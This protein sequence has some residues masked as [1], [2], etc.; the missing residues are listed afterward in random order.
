MIANWKDPIT[1][2]FWILGGTF[3]LF[4]LVGFIIFYVSKNVQRMESEVKLQHT[5]ELKHQREL[6]E[7]SVRIQE[8]ERARIAS[9]IHDDLI[10]QLHR[11][12]LGNEDDK[13][14][15]LLN[16]SIKTARII[17]HDLIPPMLKELPFKTLIYDFL[18]PYLK[19][20]EVNIQLNISEENLASELKL[21]LYRMIQELI[22][23]IEKHALATV[24]SVHYR[25]SNNYIFLRIADN[26]IGFNEKTAKGLGMKT[27][28]LRSQILEAAY[29]FRN[30]TTGGTVFIAAIERK[31]EKHDE[32]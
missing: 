3:I 7:T 21:H 6:L 1:P 2:F 13:M 16:K 5:V 9:N 31:N 12:K 28:A 26:G 29:R 24:I 22:T 10:A 27:I 20:Y 15:S 8:K 19:K 4:L 17:S 14:N 23:N 11:I 30:D 25:Q 18:E 32:Q